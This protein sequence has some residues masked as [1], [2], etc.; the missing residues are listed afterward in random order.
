MCRPA[1]GRARIQAQRLTELA[2]LRRVRDRID[3]E[4]T[5][6]LDVAA[7][8]REAGLPVGQL[9]RGFLVA[10]GVSPY[11]YVMSRRVGRAAALLRRGDLGVAEARAAVGGCVAPGVFTARFT[12]LVGVPPEAFCG[13]AEVTVERMPAHIARQVAGTVANGI[14]SGHSNG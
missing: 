4:Y 13:R 11:A 9:S 8:A 10:Y 6:P 7:L 14:S 5:R 3:R 1:W 12:E 2:R